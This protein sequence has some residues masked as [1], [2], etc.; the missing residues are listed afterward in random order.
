[1]IGLP[2]HGGLEFLICTL[3]L[4]SLPSPSL[5]LFLLLRRTECISVHIGQAGIQTGNQCWELYCLEVRQSR[6]VF[7]TLYTK[8]LSHHWLA[9]L[10]CTVARNRSNWQDVEWA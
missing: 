2:L 7:A 4:T 10:S 8:R 6:S 3:D 5:L 9:G 1:M